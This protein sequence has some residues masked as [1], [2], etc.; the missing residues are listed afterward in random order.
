MSKL[1]K[2]V[3]GF[4]T[5]GQIPIILVFGVADVDVPM[6]F[7]FGVAV[8][9]ISLWVFY[10]W[11]VRQNSR[12]PAGKERAWFWALLFFG[13]LAESVYFWR[14]IRGYEVEW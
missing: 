7:I 3:L 4:V 13:P 6:W 10:L 5:F 14:Y 9:E 12:V 2:T 8:V 11:D 1:S